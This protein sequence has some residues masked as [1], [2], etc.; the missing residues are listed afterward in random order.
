MKRIIKLTESDIT[1]I[2]KRVINEEKLSKQDVLKKHVLKNGWREVAN[3][4]GGFDI[5]YKHAFNNDYNEFLNL[6]N[7]LEVVQSEEEPNWTLYRFEKGKN[8]VI[9]NKENKYFYINHHIIWS[10]FEDGIDLNYGEIQKIMKKWLD[11]VYNLRGVTH[12][13]FHTTE[14]FELD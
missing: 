9:Y 8:M 12:L 5:L 2:V 1:R 7:N 6:F 3:R 14:I 10:F 11:E 13:P 4:I